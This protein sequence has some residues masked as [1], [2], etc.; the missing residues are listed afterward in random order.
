[1][2]SKRNTF[3]IPSIVILLTVGLTVLAYSCSRIPSITLGFELIPLILATILG[4]SRIA[5]YI[6]PLKSSISIS[7]VVIFLLMFLVGGDAY[8]T[9]SR[10]TKKIDLRLAN[11][12]TMG[13]SIFASFFLSERIFGKVTNLIVDDLGNN[14]LVALAVICL[15][16]YLV[17]T[18]VVA[19]IQSLNR[20]QNIFS[21]W[22]GTF[23]LILPF[24]CSICLAFFTASAVHLKGYYALLVIIPII[25]MIFFSYSSQNEKIEAIT[26]KATQAENHVVELTESEGRFRNAFNNAPIGM[27]LVSPY[28]K[29]LQVN[30]A[31][32]QILGY[33]DEEFL[34]TNYQKFIH[35]ADIADFLEQLGS[36]IQGKTNYF[37]REF[38]FIHKNDSIIW[39]HTSV[40]LLSQT[41]E[42]SKI[43][44]QIQDI[45]SSRKATEKLQHYAFYDSL[46]GLPNRLNLTQS[47]DSLVQNSNGNADNNFALAFL[48][49]NRFKNVND[50]FGY[51]TGDKV[52]CSVAER[53]KFGLPEQFTKLISRIGSDEFVV[54]FHNFQTQTEIVEIL[55]EIQKQLSACYEANGSEVFMTTEVGLVFCSD[56]YKN[57]EEVLRDSDAALREAKSK[58][59]SQIVI[60]DDVIS[61]KVSQ[62]IQLERDMRRA[63]E[64]N[65]LF[66]VYQ[67][68]MSIAETQLI[69]FEALIRWNHQT[70]GFVSPADFIPIAEE[71]GYIVEIGKFVIET[72]CKQIS[73]WN[74]KFPIPENFS[75]SVNVSAKQLMQVSF[76]GDLL[77]CLDKYRVKPSQLKIEITESIVIDNLE[78]TISMLKHLRA[79]GIQIS[80]DDFGTGYSSLSYLYRLPISTLKIDQSFIRNLNEAEPQNEEI[81]KTILILANNFKLDVI[82]EGIETEY[83]KTV[84]ETLGCEHGQGYLF[85]KPLKSADAEEFITD[86][87]NNQEYFL[88]NISIQPTTGQFIN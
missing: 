19:F 25:G 75:V 50:T 36:V 72:A 68:I 42:N 26:E 24:S 81:V 47:L 40:S 55:K 14:Q 64:R 67:P 53:L 65:E 5:V 17:N 41:S 87:F 63:I 74:K 71:T 46:T 82:A 35:S 56:G 54:L 43:I 49:L 15:S 4:G 20:K 86:N 23:W 31:L 84:L 51:T 30:D 48:D 29:W 69:G 60:F 21:V 1:M 18:V 85:A 44:F 57:S 83:Q 13:I 33:S 34:E 62:R 2:N 77:E 6:K 80:M 27:A 28:G 61:K 58:R 7:D 59:L 11:A 73:D 70:I 66:L 3:Y 10:F 79:L 45:T 76:V 38:R 39:T 37:E 22:S 52:L 12:A 8:I 32:I 16:Y 78:S 9:S 88:N